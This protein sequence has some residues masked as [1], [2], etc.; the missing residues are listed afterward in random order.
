MRSLINAKS[1][2][3]NIGPRVRANRSI[4]RGPAIAD[5]RV[6]SQGEV[7]NKDAYQLEFSS[8]PSLSLSLFVRVLIFSL[9]I[10]EWLA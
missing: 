6:V 9:I 3:R 4:S 10:P 5:N 8:S 1:L 2:L 7:L